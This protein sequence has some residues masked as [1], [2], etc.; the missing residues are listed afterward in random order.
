[1]L[2]SL[3]F[4][5]LAIGFVVVVLVV[6]RSLWMWLFGVNEVLEELRAIRA[7]LQRQ[8]KPAVSSTPPLPAKQTPRTMPAGWGGEDADVA[9]KMRYTD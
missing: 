1:V 3:I 7:E 2:E 9:R 4:L 5:A 6:T 8:N